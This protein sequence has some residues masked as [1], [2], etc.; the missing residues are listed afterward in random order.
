MTRIAVGGF[1][2]KTNTFAP[3]K[4]TYDDFLHGGVAFVPETKLRSTSSAT[5]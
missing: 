5:G 3:T 1:L 4:A 2:H